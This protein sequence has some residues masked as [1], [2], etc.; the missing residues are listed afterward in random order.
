LLVHLPG[1]LPFLGGMLR[2]SSEACGGRVRK[3]RIYPVLARPLRGAGTEVIR[4][5][6]DVS[7]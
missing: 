1:G 3:H 5:M 4:E 6:R 7:A 2:D